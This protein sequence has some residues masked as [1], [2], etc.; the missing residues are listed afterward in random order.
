MTVARSALWIATNIA[1]F[2][3]VRAMTLVKLHERE[4]VALAGTLQTAPRIDVAGKAD[5]R[6]ASAILMKPPTAHRQSLPRPAMPR[7]PKPQ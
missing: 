5:L 1:R 6:A 7:P 3:S 4:R 2:V